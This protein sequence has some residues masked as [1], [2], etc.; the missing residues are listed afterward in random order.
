MEI[1]PTPTHRG[2]I[3]RDQG[4]DI[5]DVYYDGYFSS[6]A[7]TELDD[8]HIEIKSKNIW[9]SKFDI[10][11]DNVDCGDIHFNW[12]GHC[13]LRY[14]DHTMME[15]Q[16]LIKPK[17]IMSRKYEVTGEKEGLLMTFVPKMNWKRMNYNFKIKQEAIEF[18]RIDLIEV[19][20]YCGYGINLMI[21]RSN[22]AG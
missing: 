8:V 4:K 12:K 1:V 19:L 20:V 2:Y 9:N 13:I 6:T 22:G 18:S 5:L 21:R 10:L 16:L 7:S 17:G 15:K 14:Y 11:K 3:I